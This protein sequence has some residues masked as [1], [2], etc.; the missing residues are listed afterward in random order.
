MFSWVF[1]F[2]VINTNKKGSAKRSLFYLEP[3]KSKGG[4]KRRL[5]FLGAIAIVFLMNDLAAFSFPFGE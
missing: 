2:T 5:Y 4:A 1:G 3:L